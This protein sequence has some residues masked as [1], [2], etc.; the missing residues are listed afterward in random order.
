MKNPFIL[1]ANEL[2]TFEGDRVDFNGDIYEVNKI[3]V[4]DDQIECYLN[5][6]DGEGFELLAAGT[7][8]KIEER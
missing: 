5:I 2:E 4:L 6:E 3:D 8:Y 1:D 7:F